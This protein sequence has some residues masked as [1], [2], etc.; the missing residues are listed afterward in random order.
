MYL[1]YFTN[2]KRLYKEEL[3]IVYPSATI[4]LTS[5]VKNSMYFLLGMTSFFLMHIL[6]N[7]HSFCV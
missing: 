5:E 4:I 3:F 7:L 1:K 6:Q 2:T